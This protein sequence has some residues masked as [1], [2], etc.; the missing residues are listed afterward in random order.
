VFEEVIARFDELIERQYPSVTAES[1]ALL[2]RVGVFSRVENRA[3]AEQ[4]RAIGE[5]FAY[6]LSRCSE[7]E[8]WAVDTEAAVAAEVA[9]ALR[10]S[11]GLAAS[12]VRYARAMRER[13]P[14]VGAV[15]AAGDI[16][17]LMFQTIV[18]RTDLIVDVDVLAAVDAE[19]AANVARWPSMT[20]GRLSAQVDKI[21]ATVDADAARR[22][23]ELVAD[24]Q[25]WVV[26]VEGGLS[27]VE[28][29]LLSPHAHALDQRLDALAAT[30]CEHDPRSREQRRA[31]AVGALAGGA[32]RLGCQCGRPDCAAGNRPAAG[33]VLIHVI[34]EHWPAS[35]LRRPRR[36][37]RRD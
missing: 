12:R 21:V 32:D 19:L 14:K 28:G 23:K 31:D 9:A 1:A 2:E 8:E 3:A 30:V 4:S 10:I 18:F 13:L 15:F 11:Q 27:H 37:V 5:L 29:S 25:L 26:D 24:R 34:A 17:Y 35:A 36:S 7:C 6:R 22:R 16:G 20:R 33:P